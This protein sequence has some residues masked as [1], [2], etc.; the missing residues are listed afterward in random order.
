MHSLPNETG[1]PSLTA[2]LLPIVIENSYMNTLSNVV[3]LTPRRPSDMQR[4]SLEGDADVSDEAK[5]VEGSEDLRLLSLPI[6]SFVM[7]DD[8]LSVVGTDASI[9]LVFRQERFVPDY[10]LLQENYQFAA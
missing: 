8:E 1:Q 5:E 6:F 3:V 4:R 2:G 7:T 9:F 10:Q